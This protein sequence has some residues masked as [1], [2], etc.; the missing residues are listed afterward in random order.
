MG[1]AIC[2]RSNFQEPDT[3]GPMEFEK[4][5]ISELK[6]ESMSPIE[7]FQ[8]DLPFHQMR[9]DAYEGRIKRLVLSNDSGTLSFQ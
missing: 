8:I 1:V 9:I 7:I 3:S 2:E 6:V 4:A 5:K